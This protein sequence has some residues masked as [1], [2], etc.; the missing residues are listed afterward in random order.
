M[1]KNIKHTKS[2]QENFSKTLRFYSSHVLWL[3]PAAQSEK[4]FAISKGSEN[5]GK[6]RHSKA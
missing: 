4:S 1:H 2:D 6:V 3:F 5:K